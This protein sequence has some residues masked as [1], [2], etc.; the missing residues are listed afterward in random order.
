MKFSCEKALLVSAVTATS[1]VAS[2]KSAIPAL[3]GL[4]FEALD[5][6][7]ITGYDL[8]TGIK[9]E[10]P[11]DI[12][13]PGDIVLNARLFGEIIR[14]LPDD[15]VTI[16]TD[17]KNIATIRCGMSEFNIM[18]T[19]AGDYPE[20]PSVDTE[21][22]I[23]VPQNIL[24]AMI[25]ETI[26]AVSDNESRPI[27]TG[28]LFEING[29]TLTLVSVDGYRLAL[30]REKLEKADL[31]ICSV[32]IPGTA[33]AEV[34]KIASDTEELVKIT[35]GS[36]HILFTLDSTVV[37]SRRLEG[38]FI[39]YKQIIPEKS[40]ISL[41]AD[42]KNLIAA[43]ERVSLIISDKVKS[44]VHCVFGDERVKLSAVTALGKA[45]DECPLAG[46]GENMEIGFNN[47]Y[48]LDALKTAPADEIQINLE[49]GITP[50][51]IRPAGDKDNFTYLVL[52]VR[53]KTSG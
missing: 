42:R 38:E 33:L 18:G 10:L 32:V 49:T 13:E 3:E 11:A 53:L 39:N 44:P 9:T 20:L 30:R 43:V 31:D 47:K 29:D 23:Y 34:E 25:A 19:P 5:N 37:I 1:K 50:C 26:F 24:K 45:S 21:N 40:R 4:L 7:K 6:I 12:T 14:K 35:L 48:L 51:V 8:K 52:P 28:T 16:E 2:S 41:T 46:D 22:S 36:K 15:I 17:D 27:H